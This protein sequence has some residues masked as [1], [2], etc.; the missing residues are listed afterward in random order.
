[1]AVEERQKEK[2]NQKVNGEKRK[3]PI[4]TSDGEI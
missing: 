1:M 2:L 4:S 3:E